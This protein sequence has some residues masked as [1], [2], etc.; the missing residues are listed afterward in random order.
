MRTSYYQDV[1]K[2]HEKFS[3]VT[4]PTFC[5]LPDDLHKFRT[6]FFCEELQEYIDSC[7]TDDLGTAFDSLVDLVYIV[8]GASMLHGI[9]AAEFNNMINE[10]ECYF[11]DIFDSNEPEKT[12]PDYLTEPN[13]DLFVQLMEKNIGLYNNA[14]ALKDKAMTYMALTGLYKSV[15]MCSSDMGCTTEMWDELWVDVQRANMSKVRAERP[16]DSKRG[17]TWDVIKPPSWVEPATQ[18]ILDKY[19]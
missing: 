18:E 6:G 1:S 5:F 11:Y 2:F 12:K 14:H 13:R 10:T 17:S 16:S 8:C 15:L 19:L 4:P 9:N 7:N 3:L